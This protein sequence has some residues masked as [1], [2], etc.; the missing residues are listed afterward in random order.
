MFESSN[1]DPAQPREARRSFATPYTQPHAPRREACEKG[2]QHGE[3]QA[4]FAV[5]IAIGGSLGRARHRAHSMSPTRAKAREVA[6]NLTTAVLSSTKAKQ[7]SVGDVESLVE[8][9]GD[10]T[11]KNLLGFV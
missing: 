5:R 4:D 11:K 6:G 3:R 10:G 2:A 8:V 7:L 9:V 1:S